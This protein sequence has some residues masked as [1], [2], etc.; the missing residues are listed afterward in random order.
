[1]KMYIKGVVVNDQQ[2]ALEF[3]TKKLGFEVKHNMPMGEHSWITLVSP[4]EENGIELLLEPDAHPAA[5]TFY[6]AL[7]AD[8]IPSTVFSVDD[9]DAEFKKLSAAGVEF[10]QPPTKAADYT[11]AVFDDTCGNLIQIIQLSS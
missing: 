5:K 2:K 1:M 11:I 4:E 6:S 10:T 9:M 7:K 8:G 3:Y